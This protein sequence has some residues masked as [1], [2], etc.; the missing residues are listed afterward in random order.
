MEPSNFFSIRGVPSQASGG[1]NIVLFFQ[2]AL[3][4][5]GEQLQKALEVLSLNPSFNREVSL[6]LSLSVFLGSGAVWAGTA[7]TCAKRALGRLRHHR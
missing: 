4:S 6:S 3:S 7:L 2:C 5:R 1:S